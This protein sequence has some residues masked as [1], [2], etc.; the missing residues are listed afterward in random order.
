MQ[1]FR[2]AKHLTPVTDPKNRLPGYCLLVQSHNRLEWIN[3]KQFRFM[4][5]RFG[6]IILVAF[7]RVLFD[8]A[9]KHFNLAVGLGVS[10]FRQP[11]RY[12]AFFARLVEGGAPEKTD[13]PP[14]WDLFHPCR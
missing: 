8:C 9:V 4:F 5:I 12:A 2:I 14:G 6:G 3:V 10:E 11:V 7:C 13:V 1:H